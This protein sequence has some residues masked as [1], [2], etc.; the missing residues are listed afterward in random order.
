MPLIATDTQRLSSWLKHEYEPSSGVCREVLPR[1][2][3]APTATVTGSVLDSTGALVGLANAADATFILMDDLT[4]ASSDQFTQVLVL[5]RGPA[6]V[7]RESLVFAADMTD[8]ARETVYGVL[9]AKDIHA[10]KQ[11]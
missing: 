8:A 6:K 2:D 11:F 4:K 3:V 7:G 9:A 10:D 1:A 5:A